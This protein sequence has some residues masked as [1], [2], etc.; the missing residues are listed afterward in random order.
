[1]KKIFVRNIK[2]A[3]VFSAKYYK[4]ADHVKKLIDTLKADYPDLDDCDIQVD[5]FDGQ[6]FSRII[7]VYA[8]VTQPLADYTSIADRGILDL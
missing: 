4:G 2:T 7:Y 6:R 8:N 5:I 1:M 3:F